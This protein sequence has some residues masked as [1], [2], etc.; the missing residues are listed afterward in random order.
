MVK[1]ALEKPKEEKQ[2]P[3]AWSHCLALLGFREPWAPRPH[4][5]SDSPP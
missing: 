5:V 1:K 4:L 2:S 3:G